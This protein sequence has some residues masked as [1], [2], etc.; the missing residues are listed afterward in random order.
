MKRKIIIILIVV[1]VAAAILGAGIFLRSRQQAAS[2]TA[3]TGGLPLASGNLPSSAGQ[4]GAVATNTTSTVLMQNPAMDYFVDA[5]GELF[6]V[7]PDGQIAM[8]KN[9]RTVIDGS[10]LGSVAAA[11]FAP[12]GTRVAVELAIDS[13]A[14]QWNIFD[15][16]K[17]SWLPIAFS[18]TAVAWSPDSSKLAYIGSLGQANT[19]VVV[20]FKGTA[21]QAKVLLHL[22]A[23]DMT[24]QWPL[25]TRLVLTERSA[26]ATT[27]SSWNLDAATGDLTPILQDRQ[28]LDLLAG[29]ASELVFQA[30]AIEG[31]TLALFDT[32]GVQATTLTFLT[33]PSKCTFW[34]QP[35]LAAAIANSSSSSTGAAATSSGTIAA[36]PKS[37]LICAIP[38]NSQNF[39]MS[40]L[41]D[42]YDQLSFF[43]ADSFYKIDLDTG[44]VIAIKNNSPQSFDA[45]D[46]KVFGNSLYFVNRVDQ[47]VYRVAL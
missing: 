27:G 15:F 42:Q 14:P 34:A 28:G 19:I 18:A 38:S 3:A 43:T 39:G 47:K 2:D 16:Q 11:A 5:Q 35:P 1:I 33:L 13:G 25:A 17:N 36:S 8:V 29:P 9:T 12:D 26:A 21:P 6:V 30:G 37:Y 4:P 40:V 20:D 44:Q 41:P 46:L 32:G 7:E 10:H 24:I 23:L 22:S 31:G 45:S